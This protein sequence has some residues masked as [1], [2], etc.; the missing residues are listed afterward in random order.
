MSCSVRLKLFYVETGKK[1]EHWDI[2]LRTE[3]GHWDIDLRANVCATEREG[4]ANSN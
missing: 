3:S 2:D 4:I 1:L